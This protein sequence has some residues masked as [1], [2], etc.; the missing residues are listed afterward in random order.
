[1]YNRR[2]WTVFLDAVIRDD[3]K[4]PMEVPQYQARRLRH[5]RDVFADD[6]AQA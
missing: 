2:L 5:G 1:M 6:Q 4:L 3:N